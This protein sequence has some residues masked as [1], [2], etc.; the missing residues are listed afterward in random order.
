MQERLKKGDDETGDC[1]K[2]CRQ[3]GEVKTCHL[4]GGSNI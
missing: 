1:V 4:Y 3:C 2:Q